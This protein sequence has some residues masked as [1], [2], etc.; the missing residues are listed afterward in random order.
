MNEFGSID[1][2]RE[3]E[4]LARAIVG[5][6]QNSRS[7]FSWVDSLVVRHAPALLIYLLQQACEVF[8]AR[9][10]GVTH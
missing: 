10:I 6:D 8:D 7:Q 9:S 5:R 1:T 4:F 2:G 3:Q